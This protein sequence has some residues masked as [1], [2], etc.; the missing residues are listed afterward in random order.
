MLFI[1]GRVGVSRSDVVRSGKHVIAKPGMMCR[2][3]HPMTS[4][5][6]GRKYV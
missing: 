3:S 6:Y 1:L 2:Y 5:S 4:S